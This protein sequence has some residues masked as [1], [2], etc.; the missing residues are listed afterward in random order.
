MEH[1]SS[2]INDP[3]EAKLR[4]GDTIDRVVREAVADAVE[5]A[6]RLGFLDENI[7]LVE[8]SGSSSAAKDKT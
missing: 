4:D 1:H 7:D 5:K 8:Q 2:D 3:I 6:R